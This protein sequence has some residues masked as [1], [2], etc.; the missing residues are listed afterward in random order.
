MRVF[1]CLK[2][3]ADLVERSPF[4][5]VGV[6]EV[7]EDFLVERVDVSEVFPYASL[8]EAI[9]VLVE[10]GRHSLRVPRFQES[11][12]RERDRSFEDVF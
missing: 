8:R 7:P 1:H 4:E 5:I 11:L 3:P 10:V 9:A 6:E 12:Y 2:A